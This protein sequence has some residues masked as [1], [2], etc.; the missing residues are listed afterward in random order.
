MS[1]LTFL[2]EF[3]RSPDQL[4]SI[5]PS[6]RAL[7]RTVVRTATLA[8]GHTVLELGAGTGPVTREILRRHPR[9]DLL[10]MEPSSRLASVLRRK[11]PELYVMEA[12]ADRALRDTLAP[13]T[14]APIDRVV[15]GLPWTLWP[16]SIQQDVLAGIVDVLAP[17][18]RFLTYTYVQS[19]LGAPGRR[20][21]DVLGQGFDRVWRTP[22][23][24]ANVPPAVV[25][26]AEGPRRGAYD[27]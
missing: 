20:F 26:V 10:A 19:Q 4:G 16:P 7:A 24:W 22:V 5:I 12:Y 15:S 6:S 17:D 11:V 14:A 18:G 9:V 27:A 25:L 13:W 2:R 21:R 23:Q 3:V 8:P 1:A